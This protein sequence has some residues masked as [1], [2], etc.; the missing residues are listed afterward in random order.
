MTSSIKS[1]YGMVCAVLVSA[2]WA[3]YF[4]QSVFGM[5]FVF[6]PS[7]LGLAL[8]V[9]FQLILV[10][11]VAR[12]VWP[13]VAHLAVES[14]VNSAKATVGIFLL[15]LALIAFPGTLIAP[16]IYAAIS[17]NQNA[18]MYAWLSIIGVPIFAVVSAIGLVL[19]HKSRLRRID[20]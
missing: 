7:K 10:V 18:A 13:R 17:G 8:L 2:V 6:L 1:I 14:V 20:A 15:T 9:I 5:I 11:I 3:L 16:F 12:F 4:G 19:I